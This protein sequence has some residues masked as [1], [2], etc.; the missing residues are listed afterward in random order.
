MAAG[1]LREDLL[2]RL[3]VFPI[4]LP[5]LRER[6]DDIG[7]LAEHFL[8]ESAQHE[9]VAKRFTREAV[10]KLERYRWPGNVRELRNAVQRAYVMADGDAINDEWLP[11]ISPAWPVPPA[12]SRRRLSRRRAAAPAQT[13]ARSPCRSARRWRRPSAS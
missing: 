6:A 11:S 5:P 8:G 13:A 12:R 7:L 10:A 9:G 4:V 1:K 2:Y 3:N